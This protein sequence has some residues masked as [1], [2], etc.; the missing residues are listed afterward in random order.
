MAE[1]SR[2]R[3]KEQF[4]QHGS[5]STGSDEFHEGFFNDDGE[6]TFGEEDE[7]TLTVAVSAPP[8]NEWYHGRLD[9]QGAEERLKQM[10]KPRSY[11]VRE[12]DRKPGSYVLSFFGKTGINHFRITAVCGDFYIG[13]R[14]FD[15]LSD[16]IAHYTHLSDLLK[17]ERLVNPV[18]PPEPVNDSKRVIAILPYTKMPD[19]DELTFQKGDIFFVHNELNEGWLWVTAHRTGEQGI[20]FE[21][22]VE[23][24]DDS[25]DPNS[26]CTIFLGGPESFLVRPSD[27]S[28]GD[29]SLF[30]HVNNQIQRFRIEKKGVRYVVGGRTFDCLDAVINRYRKEYIVEGHTLGQPVV[31]A[32]SD[33]EEYASRKEVE[34]AE[35]IYA[36][37]RE[38]REQSGLKKNQGVKMQGWLEKRSDKIKKWKCFYFV[39]MTEGSDTTLYFYDNP[40]RL[41]PKGLI[42]LSCTYLYMM[43][44]SLLERPNC[45]QLVERA[46]PCLAT[47]TY[48]SCSSTEDVQDWMAAIRPHCVAQNARAPKIER[49]KELRCL[50]ISIME[51]HRLPAKLVPSPYCIVCLNQVKTCRT[52]VQMSTDPVWDEEFLLDDIPPDVLTVSIQVWNKTKRSK[53]AQVAELTL[54]LQNLANGE[55]TETWYPLL[56]V[57]PVGDWGSMR[58]RIR[59]LD[60]LLMPKEEYSTLLDIL[61]DSELTAVKALAD[62]CHAD[63]TP[64]AAALLRVFRHQR[65][66]ARLLQG[67]CEFEIGREDE[68]STLFRSATLTT[69]LMDLYMKA[70]CFGFLDAAL[71]S[72][73]HRLVESRQSC[74]LNPSKMDNPNDAC[75]N[76]EFLLEILDELTDAIFMSS[77]ACPRTVRYICGC[78]QRSVMAKWP[79]ERL[80]RTRVISGFIFLRLLCPAILNPRQFSLLPGLSPIL[81]RA[82]FKSNALESSCWCLI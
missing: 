5:P 33:A 52:K 80:V 81:F 31:K 82:V 72:I 6:P 63:R 25:I 62:R 29:Y 23:T 57:T 76:A 15:S 71:S 56:G 50:Q 22:L 28:P 17:H 35:K 46:L 54:E 34:H 59:Y 21:E 66:E 36:T 16:L 42:D 11:L 74:E 13:G 37:L 70:V 40:K 39:L 77:D 69:T 20:V 65:Q 53:D 1:C 19:T 30:F 78:L 64:L 58:L 3:V 43:H 7:D 44:E 26:L 55:E 18:P 2:A 75:S 47:T 45:F 51:A 48:L 41:K 8:E 24:L 60:D 10:N 49:L 32:R 12:S 27:N 4:Q 61:L 67:M 38:C 79:E 73:I 14:R 68:T 9:R